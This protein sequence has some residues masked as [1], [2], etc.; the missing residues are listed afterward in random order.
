MAGVE[1]LMN[2]DTLTW[3]DFEQ[4][5]E[6]KDPET[7]ERSSAFTSFEW[8][9][10]TKPLKKIGSEVA[11]P[12]ITLMVTP[13]CK[14][15]K[16]SVVF[17]DKT[18]AKQLLSHEQLHYDVAH[19][20]GRVLVHRLNQLH[21]KD[22]ATLNAQAEVLFNLHFRVRPKLINRH[23]DRSTKH[24]MDAQHQRAWKEMM[25]ATLADKNALMFRGY[26]L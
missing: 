18:K 9:W 6:V 11:F 8:D 16:D 7:G 2:P 1:L 12:D 24:G 13:A 19:V 23:Y 5:D 17:K 21:A 25:A 20:C 14:V 3:D 4:V 10:P 15:R 26:W 22:A